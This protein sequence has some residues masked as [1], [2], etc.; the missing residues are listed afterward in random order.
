MITQKV[1]TDNLEGRIDP[2]FY[3]HKYL[4]VATRLKRLRTPTKRVDSF[5]DVI[6][7]P[8]G[9]AIKVNDYT[10][11]GVPLI[12]IENIDKTYGVSSTN[13]TFINEKLAS[14]L[15]R[16]EVNKGDLVISQRGTLGL[17]GVIRDDL[18]G[19][20][21]SA[22][23][24][25][26]KNLKEVIPDYLQFFFSSNLGQI[27]LERRTSG[28]VQ[29]KITT[30]DI[31][32]LLVPIPS[33]KIQ[34]KIV[35]LFLDAIKDRE[36][37]LRQADELLNSIDG[38]VRQQLGIDYTELEEEKIYTINSKNLQDNRQDPYYY[39]SKFAKLLCSVSSKL[40]MASLSDIAEGVFNGNTPAKDKYTDD[41]KPIVKVSCLKKNR[42]EWS[43][44]AYAKEDKKLN[45]YIKDN[46]ILLLSSAHQAEYLGKNPCLV[47]I[48]SSL[49][50]KNITF[51]G[52]LICI[53]P[54]IKLISPYYLLAILRLEEY[55]QLINR[56]KRGQ[57]SHIYPNDLE[58]IKIPL[59]EK[60]KQ[61]AIAQEFQNRLEKTGQLKKEAS[62]LLEEAKKKVEEMI[63]N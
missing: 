4:E 23:L 40:K 52:E 57:T 43:N 18:D 32:T 14:S 12:R 63:L 60:E 45:K 5:S 58:K 26:I 30:E 31:K 6:C 3:K 34:Q 24:I 22:N 51:V 39:N 42:V 49:K 27:Q 50:D 53:R 15:K 47:E 54:N 11:N 29:T 61:D 28:Q 48:P 38:Y 35:N 56:E 16:Y 21:I 62:S 13:A 20:V 7:G 36:E 33:K 10:D 44:L 19:A 2:H 46:D 1:Y 41:G 17:S 9:S 55:H 37:K 25:A 59:A 8:F